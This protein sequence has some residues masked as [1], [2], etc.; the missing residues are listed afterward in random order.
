MKRIRNVFIIHA[1]DMGRYNGVYGHSINTPHM[2]NF[3][4]QGTVFRDAH[5]AAPTCSPSRAAMLTGHTAHEMGMLGLAHRGFTIKDSECHLARLLSI[6]GFLTVQSGLQHEYHQDQQKVYDRVLEGKAGIKNRDLAAAASAVDFLRTH[7]EQP[8]FLWLGLFYPHREFLQP[9]PVRHRSERIKVPDP[10]PDTPANRED[11]AGYHASVE[12]TDQVLGEVLAA[13]EAS[14]QA[15]ETL[16]ILTTDHG[17]A[18]PD[19]KSSLTAH[20]T[21]ITWVMRHPDFPGGQVSDALVSHLDM[22]PTILDLLELEPQDGLHGTS[23]RPLLV[24]PCEATVREDTFAEVNVHAGIEPKRGVRTKK[25]SYIRI[26]ESNL[27]PVMANTDESPSKKTWVDR[28]WPERKRDEVQLY[29]LTFDPQ[30]RH[31]VAGEPAYADVRLEMESRLERWMR[32]THDPLLDGPLVVPA[33]ATVC[34]RHSMDPHVLVK[35]LSENFQ[36]P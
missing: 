29:D 5:C 24:S 2:K 12:V 6:R 27:S 21:G 15:E 28:R 19:M 17:I 25:Y 36:V 35:T 9:D 1:H 33:G 22:V 3:A 23:L 30:E 18:F 34:E 32:E 4:E 10:L 20:G 7:P 13:L 26:F 16:V 8:W 31:N 14:G 11:M